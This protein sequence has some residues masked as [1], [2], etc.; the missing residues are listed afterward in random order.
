MLEP[1]G[2]PRVLYTVE[3]LGEMSSVL[4]FTII[5]VPPTMT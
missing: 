4:S 1:L 5:V 3:I 2:R